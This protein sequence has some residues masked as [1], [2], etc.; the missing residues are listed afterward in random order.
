MDAPQP[1]PVEQVARLVALRDAERAAL[2]AWQRAAAKLPE[3]EAY[4]EALAA[5]EAA[6]AE[7]A[8]ALGAS[9]SNWDVSVDLGPETQPQASL[10]TV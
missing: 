10:P 3:C 1:S 4:R 5:F 9:P 8:K 7:L 6:R 2:R